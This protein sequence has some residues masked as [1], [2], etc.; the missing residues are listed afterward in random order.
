[1]TVASAHRDLVKAIAVGDTARA[2][3]LNELIPNAE[4]Q[5]YHTFV[6]AFFSLMLEQ[7]FGD[8]ASR[9]AIAEFVNEMRYDYRN[10]QPPIKPLML[11]GL[12]RASCGDEHFLD[13]ISSED[14][15]Q[16]EYQVIRKIVLQSP[17]ITDRIDD[18]LTEA[19]ALVREWE[20]EDA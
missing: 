3:E 1:M 10:A 11:E 5:D 12:I 20:A 19:E 6:T 2:R 7:R 13:E 16:G 8:N 18:F 4:R 14:T 17:T 9:D 15:L